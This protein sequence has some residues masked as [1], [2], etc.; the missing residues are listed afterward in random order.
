MYYCIVKLRNYW[1]KTDVYQKGKHTVGTCA[2]CINM[3]AFI[4]MI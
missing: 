3:M 2:S 4:S 1:N